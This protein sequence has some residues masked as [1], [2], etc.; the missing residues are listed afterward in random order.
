MLA[1]PKYHHALLQKEIHNHC[2][3]PPRLFPEGFSPVKMAL[4]PSPRVNMITAMRYWISW[5]TQRAGAQSLCSGSLTWVAPRMKRVDRVEGCWSD[6]VVVGICSGDGACCVLR[7][8]VA[9]R[10][11][12]F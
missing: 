11:G 8:L 2:V 1:R 9:R 4:K 10:I 7:I 6:I 12:V 3:F 5:T